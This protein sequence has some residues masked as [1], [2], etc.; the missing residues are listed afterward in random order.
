MSTLS[1][2]EFLARISL[3]DPAN[4]SIQHA[5]TDHRLELLQH[6]NIPTGS[7]ILELG[8]G[9]G[10]CTT[11]LAYAVGEAGRVVAVDPAQLDYGVSRCC[12]PV[13]HTLV[14]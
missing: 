3:H 8:C 9:Q 7:K 14:V 10:D 4:F 5:Q 2:T 6:W 11:A 12:A 1:D 13:L